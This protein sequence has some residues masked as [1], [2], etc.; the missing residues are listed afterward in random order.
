MENIDKCKRLNDLVSL[1][2]RKKTIV[3]LNPE[4][5]SEHIENIDEDIIYD[6][7]EW[8][9]TEELNKTVEEL[10]EN[11]E[12]S[13][14][15]KILL[16]YE[17]ICKKYVYDDNLISY[18]KKEDDDV[19]S[20][21]DWYGRDIDQ[22]WITNREEHNRRVCYEL[23]RYLAKALTNLLKDNE[24]YTVCIHWNKDLT[25]YFVGLTCDDYSVIL[26]PDD[27]FN[28]KD[29]TRIKSGLTIEGIKILEDKKNKFGSELN[30]YNENREEYAT[31]QIENEI[32]KKET[33]DMTENSTEIEENEEVR[34]LKKVMEILVDEHNMD[35]QGIYEYM[36]EIID[37]KLGT[38]TREKVWKKIEGNTKESTRYIR[39]LLVKIK[40]KETQE[41]KL[42]LIDGNAR[43]VREFSEKEF[44]EK[45]PI[46]IRYNELSRGNY[47][48]Y[49]GS[50]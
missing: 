8:K 20:L 45:K 47:D 12:I 5:K 2:V 32:H 26:D 15:N 27:F 22:E 29:I 9:V 33:S 23:S 35:E 7:I 46:F 41:Q 13:I 19:Y 3:V 25:H 40:D 17:E 14:E 36:K 28:I 16:I 49:D 34:F 42:F 43:A 1:Y 50:K 24:D 37:I 48:Y 6:K 4:D 18:I 44:E 31:N 30:K 21:P 38:D 39:C 11:N 10:S